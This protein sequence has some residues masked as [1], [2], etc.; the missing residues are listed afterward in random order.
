MRRRTSSRTTARHAAKRAVARKRRLSL[1]PPTSERVLDAVFAIT[2]D[3]TFGMTEEELVG[4]YARMLV[5]LFPGRS[6]CIRSVDPRTLTLSSLFAEGRLRRGVRKAPLSIRP[7]AV[8]KTK[9]IHGGDVRLQISPTYVRIFEETHDLGIAIPLV[10]SGGLY[11]LLNVEYPDDVAVREVD[12]L[13]EQDE[14][15]LI[16]LA[17]QLSVALRNKKLAQETMFLRDYQAKLIEEA[18]ALIF[19][20]DR[21]GRV[22]IFNRALADLTGFPP[23]AILGRDLREWLAEHGRSDLATLIFEGLAGHTPSAL[24]VRIPS[25]SGQ[26]IRAAFNVAAVP[27]EGGEIE[28]VVAIGQDLTRLKAL[29]HQVIQAEKLA[30]LGQLAA[31]VV[32]EINNPLTSITVYAD[33]LKK[34]LER[35]G[36]D[37]ADTER[38]GKILDGAERILRFSRDLVAYAR[39]SGDVDAVSVNEVVE[40]SLSFCEHILKKAEARVELSLGE[41]PPIHGI[42]GQLQQVFINL[43]TNASHAMNL[44][45]GT[46]R[47]A[48]RTRGE[49]EVEVDVGDDGVGIKPEDMPRIFEPFF[50]TKLPGKGTGLGL[51]I[52]KNIVDRHGGRVEVRSSPSQGASFKVILPTKHRKANE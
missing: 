38:M 20:V 49:N 16:P 43:V 29:E 41:L 27:A 1:S 19:A 52:V 39:P 28:A 22:T 35:E 34:K 25:R 26:E 46:I 2:K 33:Y 45:G 21:E 3:I 36:S 4:R 9:L 18:N 47:V 50:T 51:S 32:H 44:G 30:T 10:A 17:N 15:V 13:I 23:R 12:A 48:T 31:G 8:A 37:P 14:T 24:E 7:T 42:K 6:L 11:G 40:Q 5:A